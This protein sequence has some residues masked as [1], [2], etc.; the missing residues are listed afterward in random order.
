[1]VS[2]GRSNPSQVSIYKWM[3]KQTVVYTT[4]GYYSVFKRNKILTSYKNIPERHYVKW[5]N[6]ATKRQI[7]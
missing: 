2:K 6:P 1:M 5:N 3:Y 4:M 7:L